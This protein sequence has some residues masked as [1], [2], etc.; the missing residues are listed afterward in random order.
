MGIY[1]HFSAA[2]DRIRQ[3]DWEAAFEDALQIAREGKL[4]GIERRS[5]EGHVYQAGIPVGADEFC[6]TT[7]LEVS[8]ELRTGSMME[9]HFIPR[10]FGVDEPKE[11][12]NESILA[13]YLDADAPY[14]ISEPETADILSNK[15]QGTASHIWLLAMACVF[16]DRFPDAACVMGDITAG[17][18]NRALQIAEDVLGRKLLPPLA[19]DMER[20]LARIRSLA[21]GDELTAAKLFFEIYRGLKDKAFNKFVSR[22]F[23]ADAV[24]AAFR[25][26]ADQCGIYNTLKNWLLLDKPFKDVARML[27]TDPEGPQFAP[28]GFVKAVLESKLHIKK[29]TVFDAAFADNHSETPD[30]N[31][32]LLIRAYVRIFGLRNRAIDRFIPLEQ[33]KADCAAV[34]GDRCDVDTLFAETAKALE[35][36]EMRKEV[37]ELYGK[38]EKAKKKNARYSMSGLKDLFHW[39]PS[40]AD[41]V[42]PDLYDMLAAFLRMAFKTTE[43]VWKAF[44]SA[45]RDQRIK[46]LIWC[47][48]NNF[49]LPD[50]VWNRLFENVTEETGMRRYVALFSVPLKENDDF[51]IARLF[52]YNEDLYDYIREAD[53]ST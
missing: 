2:P 51:T 17:Q 42:P 35:H 14:E 49:L 52:L 27:V 15:T 43:E 30:D 28:E 8:G 11:N 4:C 53:C 48:G 29:K 5:Y 16:C 46:L 13:L 3:S 12:A 39:T 32:M 24:Y 21:D 25:D 23:S 26:A 7:G 40:D 22:S 37:E 47:A 36:D 31:G 34:F 45:S 44:L 38:I 41:K 50:D 20:L 9:P 33:I 10:F 1:I 6:R 19:Y 18:V